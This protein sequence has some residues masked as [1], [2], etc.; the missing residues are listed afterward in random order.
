MQRKYGI[1]IL[2]SGEMHKKLQSLINDIADDYGAIKFIPHVSIA[3]IIVRD[4]ELDNVKEKVNHLAK[5]LNRF[6]LRLAGYGYKNDKHRCIYILAN[7]D[8]LEKLFKET[9][10]IFPDAIIERNR[11]MPHLSLMYGEYPDNIK[12]KI[13]TK[14]TEKEISFVAE[15]LDLCF[16]DG[17]E[18]GWHSIYHTKFN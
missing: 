5:K 3:G 2:P 16:S 12:H 13:I 9:A 4:D 8:K 17:P 15:G 7:S 6:T 1:W 18:E 14:Y 11:V 10:V